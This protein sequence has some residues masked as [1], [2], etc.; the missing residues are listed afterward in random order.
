MQ[1][2]SLNLLALLMEGKNLGY[3][4]E[5]ERIILK[6]GGKSLSKGERVKHLAGKILREIKSGKQIVIIVSA[7]GDTTDTLIDFS[8][9]A[10]GRKIS[11]KDLDETLSMGERT[12]ARLFTAA[13]KAQ[14]I[15]AKF[16]DPDDNNWPII[17]DNNFGDA[18]PLIEESLR[19]IQDKLKPL[20]NEGIV[21]VIPGFIGKTLNGEITTL[22]RG[23]SDTTAFLVAKAIGASEVLLITDVKGIMSA[24]PKIVP[25]PRKIEKIEVEKLMNLCNLDNKFLHR[26]ALKIMDGSFKVKI[27]SYYTKELDEGTV[28]EGA[29]QEDNVS[30]ENKPLAAVTILTETSNTPEN[31]IHILETI[32]RNKI[33]VLMLLADTDSLVLYVPDED[34]QKTVKILHSN[35]S[36]KGKNLYIA[37]KRRI[38]WTKVSGVEIEKIHEKIKSLETN[39]KR[40]LGLSTIASNIHIFTEQNN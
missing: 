4:K 36:L 24:D 22:G 28:I 16:L 39:E 14:G 9:R 26:K 17:T 37:A 40:L 2:N 31:L 19:R 8:A 21:P 7:I 34:A 30:S 15:K 23:G 1:E 38:A 13:L 10:C 5:T 29:I 27:V 20:L 33:S 18:N 3:K 12:S 6:F 35:I 32:M 11:P 25:K